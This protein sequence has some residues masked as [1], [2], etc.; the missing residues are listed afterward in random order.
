MLTSL[1]RSLVLTALT[2]LVLTGCGQEDK[3]QQAQDYLD[4]AQTY[5]DQHQYRAAMIEITNAMQAA[6]EDVR[7]AVA[8]ADVYN[9]L[10]AS[11]RAS[12]LLE[13]HL[14]TDPQAVALTL[15]EA[16]IQQG[17]FLSAE[18]TLAAFEPS[19]DAERRRARLYRADAQRIRGHLEESEAAFEALLE[20]HPGDREIQLRLAENHL[21][22]EQWEE[23]ERHISALREQHPEEPEVWHLS[24]ILAWQNNDEEL[25]EQHLTTALMHVP[26][27]DVMLPERANILRLLSDALTAQGKSAEALVYTKALAEESPET[28]E[29]EQ[30][31]REASKAAEQGELEK[32]E[33]ILESLLEENPDSRS[34]ALMLGMLNLRQGDLE[35]AE[36]LLSDSMDVETAG[37][38]VIRAT[39]MVQAEQGDLDRALKTV[40][41]SLKAHPDNPA[42]LALHGT[43]A[44]KQPD[45]EREGYLSLQ[46]ALAQDPHRG[47]LRLLLARHHLR[48]NEPE[49][50]MAQL[51]TG[52]KHQPADWPLTRVYMSRLFDQGALA[53]VEQALNT[54]REAAPG[55]RETEL[56]EAQFRYRDGD[57]QGAIRALEAMVEDEPDFAPGHAS[58][59]QMYMDR[60]RYQEALSSMERVASL[61]S[62]SLDPLRAGVEIIERSELSSSPQEWLLSLAKQE[63]A[64]RPNAT[65]L[66][67]MLYREADE[68]ERAVELLENYEGEQTDYVQQVAAL[69]YRDRA[70][71]LSQAGDHEP[72]RGL[73]ERA[74]ESFPTS[75]TLNLDLVK[76]ELAQER[77]EQAGILLDDL[78]ERHPDNPHVAL[79][80]ARLLQATEGE[81]AAYQALKRDWDQH[82]DTAMAGTLIS[83]ARKQAPE[84]VSKIL[85]TWEEAAPD[86]RA[87][88]L[89]MAEEYQRRDNESAATQAYEQLI[90]ANPEDA[91]AL[92]NLAWLLREDDL[93]RARALA[94]RAA[95]L[96]PESAPILDTYGWLLHLAGEHDEAVTYLER[97]AALAPEAEAIQEN[98]EAARAAR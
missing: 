60:E 94:E 11:R 28:V 59:A 90:D 97:A 31:L 70:R 55:A 83:L 78:R 75:R 68:V 43:L 18:E 2:L 86:S 3:Q 25:A 64:L 80:N 50:A 7:Y 47:E 96:Q 5:L 17:K 53:E 66:T 27:A 65:A 38:D 29:A 63:P 19:S 46:K 48:K 36:S 62:T 23:A 88:L 21:F 4:R 67:A 54:L 10:G 72:A 61:R 49:Q 74:L 16:Y 77:F 45:T 8:L 37:T 32:A 95:E 69:V 52:F 57:R 14:D 44:I 51:R 40:E 42:L 98:L 13:P 91:V 15:A 85:Q 6:P 20:D 89:F 1:P 9:T 26:D 58:L 81:K 84:A 76:L 12:E 33:Q 87:R 93:P 56:F 34:A 71:Q 41:R 35:E 22:A 92:N 24:A 73:L 82:P 79:L 39:A 30:R